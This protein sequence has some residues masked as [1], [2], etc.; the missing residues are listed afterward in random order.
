MEPAEQP[1]P[2]E[3]TGHSWKE[4]PA[5]SYLI[6]F[7]MLL[8]VFIAAAS[9]YVLGSLQKTP[10]NTKPTEVLPNT[11]PS[12]VQNEIAC[13]QDAMQCPNGSWVG[14]TGQNCE[15]VCPNGKKQ[16][17]CRTDAECPQGYACEGV[18]GY[19]VIQ[20]GDQSSPPTPIITDGVCKLKQGGTCSTDAD[21]SAGLICHKTNT[22]NVC[23]ESTT[24]QMCSGPNDT[25][26][27]EGYQCIQS[28]GPPVPRIDE[29]APPYY[30]MP[31][32]A[33]DRPRICPICLSSATKIATPQGEIPVTNL[34]EGMKV[35]SLNEKGEKIVSAILKTGY[36]VAPTNHIMIHLKLADGRELFVSPGHPTITG[37]TVGQLNKGDTYNGS[38]IYS[39]ER[40][41]YMDKYTYD[42][43]PDSA[44]GYYFANSILLDSTLKE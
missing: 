16:T 1:H 6:I 21:C 8:V 31:N 38:V 5:Q 13:S 12:P 23:V 14:R 24:T 33:A 39:V 41:P 27:S 15:F 11:S 26:C 17:Q 28:C 3:S 44:T 43:L 10:P 34:K 18:S 9:G 42:L 32:E 20:P 22:G 7:S 29:P 36:T 25:S 37:S 35:W 30:C 19:G 40:V 2:S 4:K